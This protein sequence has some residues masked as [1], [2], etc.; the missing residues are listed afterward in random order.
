MENCDSAAAENV[1]NLF[2]KVVST[3]WHEEV[4]HRW[5]KWPQG[6]MQSHL[7]RSV[8]LYFGRHGDRAQFSTRALLR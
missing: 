5:P 1:Q 3:L 4:V 6:A 8:L 7:L 2:V